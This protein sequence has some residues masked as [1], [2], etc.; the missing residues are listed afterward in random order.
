MLFRSFALSKLISPI[1][2]ALLVTVV[3]TRESFFGA[4][5]SSTLPHVWHSPQR[6]THFA[7]VQPHSAQRNG[8]FAGTLAMTEGYFFLV[9]ATQLSKT[10]RIRA[11]PKSKSSTGAL[12]ILNPQIAS[13]E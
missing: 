12:A 13:G 2:K 4:A 6:P 8:S 7:V 3:G 1:G 11:N 5:I 9:T 10:K